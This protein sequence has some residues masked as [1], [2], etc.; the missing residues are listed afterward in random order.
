MKILI[1]ED[2]SSV[3]EILQIAL[4][5]EK[6]AID[7]AV[8]GNKAFEM[9]K[10]EKYDVIVLDIV[11][12]EKSGF[13]IIKAL[14]AMKNNTPI[15]VIS[16][17]DSLDDKITALNLGADDYMVKDFAVQE[18]VARIKSLIRRSSK[19]ASKNLFFCDDLTL[20]LSD[21]IVRRA[22]KPIRL[23]KKE[24]VIL[25]ELLRNK[26]R[27]VTTEELIRVAWGNLKEH[28]SNKL[29]V[30]MRALRSKVDDPFQKHL[31]QTVRGFGYQ[32]SSEEVG[33]A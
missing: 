5:K 32:V 20:N 26:D 2:N 29:N 6:F 10:T 16:N 15:L 11:L 4:S 8:D 17:R 24:F 23:T 7:Y 22:G 25:S 14:R 33:T 12:P 13:E 9:A 30:H 31:I 18:L 21:M 19:G 28:N 1:V 3:L 27:V